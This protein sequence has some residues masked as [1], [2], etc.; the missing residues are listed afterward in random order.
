M[1]EIDAVGLGDQRP[2]ADQQVAE[3][4]ARRDAGVPVMRR[5]VVEDLARVLPLA[6][7]EHALPGHEHALEQAHAGRLP[8]VAAEL[9]CPPRRGAR[10]AGRRWSAP[11]STGTAQQTAKSRVGGGHL[12]AGHDQQLVHVGRRR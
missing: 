1:V 8:V 5:V 4:G 11:A 3:A 2:G 6:G 9:R 10:P 12:A 7:A